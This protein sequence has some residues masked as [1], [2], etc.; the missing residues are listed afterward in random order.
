M[1]QANPSHPLKRLPSAPLEIL[2]RTWAEIDGAALRHNVAAVRAHIGKP[3]A[4]MAVVKADAYG[5]GLREVVK[6]VAHDVECFGVASLMEA[7]VVR[8]V[9][10]EA[11]VFLLSPVLPWE[12]ALVVEL[13]FVPWISSLD[14]ARTFAALATP[15]KP[16]TLHVKVDTGMGRM[17]VWQ[18]DA[19]ALLMALREERNLIV[20]GVATHLPVADEDSAYTQAQ[21]DRFFQ[22]AGE[23]RA[24]FPEVR[25]LHAENSAGALGYPLQ[26]G[27]LIR[28]GLGLYGCSPMPEFQRVLRPTLS[29]RARITLLRDLPV[30]RSIG[31]GRAFITTRPTRAATVCAGYAD[32]YRRALSGKGAWVLI[33]GTRCPVLGRISM[34]QIVV[35]ATDVPG[36]IECNEIVTLLGADGADEITASD[37]AALA[38]TIP[39][40]ILTGIGTRVARMP[41]G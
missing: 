33:R 28:L 25:M 24:I 27:D 12:R 14:E 1:H 29:W 36:E 37:L 6:A 19:I 32:G 34:D 4:V 40:E 21:L 15:E 17:G 5:H 2:H 31:Y 35:D 11:R 23:I 9:H 3:V 7:E 41:I 30:G 18:E 38:G 22:L 13:G 39:W 26:S 10:A 8:S 20:E 16:F